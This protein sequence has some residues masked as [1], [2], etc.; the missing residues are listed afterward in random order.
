MSIRRPLDFAKYALAATAGLLVAASAASVAIYG[1]NIG[2]AEDWHMVAAMTGHQDNLLGW[3]W[4]QNNE[5]RLPVQRGLYLVLLWLTGD[6]RAGMIFNQLLLLVMALAMAAGAARARGGD[7]RLSDLVYPLA[8]LHLGHW[9]HMVWGWN[10]HFVW[11]AFLIGILIAIVM[12]TKDRPTRRMA[13]CVAAAFPLLPISGANG[14]AVTLALAPWVMVSGMRFLR[15]R[16][17]SVATA[18]PGFALM[19]S[20]IFSV[21]LIRIY[22]IGYEHP[23]WSPPLAN[24][25]QFMVA[26]EAYFALALGPAAKWFPKPAAIFVLAMLLGGLFLSLRAFWTNRS[27]DRARSGTLA[28]FIA[29]GC[30]LGVAISLARGAYPYPMP[31][32]YA[33]FSVQPLLASA[34]AVQLYAGPRPRRVLLNGL[35]L[36][37]FLLLPL[38]TT[39]GFYWRDWYDEGMRR[40]EADIEASVPIPELVERNY[41]FLLHWDKDLLQRSIRALN[42]KGI[43]PFARLPSMSAE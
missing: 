12:A 18:G 36:L 15:D 17:P 5:H 13:W 9:P 23:S 4:S 26:A 40:V 10:I 1:R 6:F 31:D 7:V 2:L 11:S 3:L 32:R 19:G 37:F 24:F 35:A 34:Y 25:Q 28:L 22:F 16:T 27:E 43:G 39:A 30:A 21:L 41:G 38:N 20:A 33:L 14:L 8:L 29:C 42:E